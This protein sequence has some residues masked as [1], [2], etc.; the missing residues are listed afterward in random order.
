MAIESAQG[1]NPQKFQKE[2]VQ[3]LVAE[4]LVAMGEDPDREGLRQTPFRVAEMF[5]EL[6]SGTGQPCESF[7]GS[8]FP[9]GHEEMVLLRDISF[10]SL[11]EH[12]LLPF[13]GDVHVAYIPNESG[14]IAG[15]SGIAKLVDGVSR[16]LQV[17]ERFTT[18]IANA[19]Q[20]LMKPKGVLVVVEAEHLC[21]SM[22]GSKKVGS[23]AM[24][25]AVRGAF[26]R[27][28]VTRAE[29][30]ELIA[31]GRDGTR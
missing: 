23:R 16:R 4:L 25:S 3:E 27:D 20:E 13:F 21:M 18:E 17:Q 6:L 24:T 29:A 1:A 2:R 10:F 15:L 9:A 8:M 7:L 26:K 11:C 12:H 30:L 22:R 31:K 5:E 28:G 14:Q 19:I